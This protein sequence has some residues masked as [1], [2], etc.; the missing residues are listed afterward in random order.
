MARSG[1]ASRGWDLPEGEGC[2]GEGAGGGARRQQLC[3][4]HAIPAQDA[5]SNNPLSG[6][7]DLSDPSSVGFLG[8]L[9]CLGLL[10]PPPPPP[11]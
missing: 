9:G 8:W 6:E 1:L 7:S 2:S 11:P 3:S 5:Q 10:F 4:S